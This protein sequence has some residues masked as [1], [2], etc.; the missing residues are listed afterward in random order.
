MPF[1]TM[2]AI[3]GV[4]A[5]LWPRR[6]VKHR[7][8]WRGWMSFTLA[9]AS[10][11]T[12]AVGGV[13]AAQV[14][15]RTR[16]AHSAKEFITPTTRIDL[17]LSSEVTQ[18][19]TVPGAHATILGLSDGA[20]HLSL[21]LPVYLIGAD[22]TWRVGARV[23]VNG[24]LSLGRDQRLFLRAAQVLE[25]HP[26]AGLYEIVDQLR[27]GVRE[28][29]AHLPAHARGLIPGVSIG[30][31]RRLPPHIAEAMTATSLTHITAVSGAHVAVVLGTVLFVLARAPVRIRAIVAFVV[32]GAM[33][34][35]VLPTPSVMRAAGMGALALY[36]LTRRRPRLAL[37]VLMSTVIVLLVSDPWLATSIGFGLSVAATS[38]ILLFTGPISRLLGGGALGRAV[39]VP[40]AAQVWCAPLLLAFDASIATY[41][42]PANLLAVPA[43]APATILGLASAVT[44]LVSPT[45]A[46]ALAW[47]GSHFTA[48]IATV[49]VFF[50]GLPGARI[51]W[52]SGTGG[53]LSLILATAVGAWGL[54]RVGRTRTWQA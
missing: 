17:R 5:W 54:R 30:D 8:A 31:D 3:L 16:V 20:S 44:S 50:A 23:R 32:L 37:P 6:E 12:L 10:A 15:H 11:V 24:S 14:A 22:P 28:A 47:L 52:A 43:L 19:S 49:A 4:A 36:A 42:V 29:S 53:V 39:A 13:A 26:P 21:R 1:S 18:A 46:A 51:P 9:L 33:V 40:F 25:T 45:L 2:V 27:S 7:V 35:V 38:G 48:W 34:I 41:S